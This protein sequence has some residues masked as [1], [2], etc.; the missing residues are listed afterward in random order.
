MLVVGLRDALAEWAARRR[1]NPTKLEFL[2]FGT[3]PVPAVDQWIGVPPPAADMSRV[4]LRAP[5]PKQGEQPRWLE[6]RPG[7][8][9]PDTDEPWCCWTS[10]LMA[11]RVASDLGRATLAD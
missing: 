6:F 1:L 10:D 7:E 2:L 5:E 4:E 9:T 3:L 11:V 8:W